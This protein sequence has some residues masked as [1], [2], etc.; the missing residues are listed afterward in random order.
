VQ[1]DAACGPLLDAVTIKELPAPYP[2]KG[3]DETTAT[4]P[5]LFRFGDCRSIVI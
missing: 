1:E 4:D 5:L 3:N 2:T